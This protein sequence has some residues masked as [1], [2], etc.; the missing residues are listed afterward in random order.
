MKEVKVQEETN[1][2][3]ELRV[4]REGAQMIYRSFNS[5]TSG[6]VTKHRL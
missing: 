1:S 6:G 5:E 3:M 4:A 2:G